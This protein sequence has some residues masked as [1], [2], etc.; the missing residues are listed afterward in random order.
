[1]NLHFFIPGDINTLTGGY[2]YDKRIAEGLRFKAHDVQVH[3][4]AGDFPFP[5]PESRKV[6][7]E[8]MTIIPKNEAIIIDSLVFGAI[9][10]LLREIKQYHPII[11]LVHLPLSVNSELA[12]NNQTMIRKLEEE[13]FSYADLIIVSSSFTKNLIEQAGINPDLIKVVIPGVEPNTKKQNYSILPRKLI[14]ISNYTRNKGYLL[15]V[16]ALSGL[17]HLDW[18][19][20]CY[21]DDSFDP[22]YVKEISEMIEGNKLTGRIFLHSSI[23][24]MELSNAYVNSDALIHPSEFE[25]YGMVLTEALAH[26][27]PV[28]AST[29]GA[30]TQTV[31]ATM[32]VFFK[33]N[34]R[35]SFQDAI[36]QLFLDQD[37]YHN[38]CMEASSYINQAQ[39]W[40]ISVFDFESVL[41]ELMK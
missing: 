26:G 19:L 29:G 18:T 37:K 21:G 12:G 25:S 27:I 36:E 16:D 41:Q 11:A 35:Q 20:D 31:P 7:L 40:E 28:V 38:L 3:I 32:A 10:E 14:T 1:M 15:L 34:D 23:S 17:K 9:P 8:S 6:C 4:L 33:P 24:G 13:A 2:I 39:T 5:S 30:V 22:E